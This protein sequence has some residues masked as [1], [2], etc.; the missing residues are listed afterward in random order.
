MKPRHILFFKKEM[1]QQI[2][3]KQKV[4]RIRKAKERVSR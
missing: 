4:K 1:D 2:E 3:I